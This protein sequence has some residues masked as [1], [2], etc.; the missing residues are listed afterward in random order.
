GTNI[1]A[2]S[3]ATLSSRGATALVKA[4]ADALVTAL[5]GGGL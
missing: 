4:T 2:V 1:D 5:A 3:G